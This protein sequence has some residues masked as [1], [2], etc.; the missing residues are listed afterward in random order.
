MRDRT[1]WYVADPMCSWCWGFSTVIEAIEAAYRDRLTVTMVMGGLRAGTTSPMAPAQREEILHHWKAVQRRTG[2]AFRFEGAMP[3]GFVYD[4]EPPCRAVVAMAAV[5]P[6]ATRAYFERVQAAFYMEGRD[7]TQPGVLVELAADCGV[8]NDRFEPAFN[9]VDTKARTR[10]EFVRV[11]R[12]GVRGFPTLLLQHGDEVR[13]LT[14]GYRPF[15][16]LQPI[17][18]DWLDSPAIR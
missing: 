13:L 14:H 4:T 10:E 17:L 15:E 2:Q 16:E 12:W 5:K 7:V 6:A 8:E 11:Y 18:D 9:S 1:V 3:D